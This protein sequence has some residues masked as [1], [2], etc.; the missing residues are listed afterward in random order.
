MSRPPVEPDEYFPEYGDVSYDVLHYDLRLVYRVDGN[1][2]EGHAELHAVARTDVDELHLDLRGLSVSK[3]RV[4]VAEVAKFTVRRG[5]LVV[6]TRQV[7]EEGQE[8]RLTIRYDGKPR[9]ISDGGG[10][11]GWEE[12]TDGVLVAGQTNGAASWFPCNDRP[13]NK[14]SYR[15]DVTTASPYY[16]VANG[17]LTSRRQGAGRTTWVYE[18]AE[19]M[20]TYLAT[21]QIGRYL[22]REVPGSPVPM[23]AMLPEGRLEDFHAGFGR[24]PEMMDFFVRSFGPYPF[25]SYAVVITE[26]P[27]EIPLEAQSLSIFGSNFLTDDWDS[28]RLVAHELSHQWFGNSVTA[29]SWRDIWLHEGFACYAEWLWSEESGGPSAHERAVEHWKKLDQ[30]PQD[31]LLG[32]PG[33]DDMFDDRVYKRGALLLHTLR[34]EVGDDTFFELLQEWTRRHAH[35]SVTTALFIELA[36]D[37]T[38]RPLG[39][40][41]TAWLEETEL[42]ALPS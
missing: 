31:L 7:I 14:A 30:L 6:R 18:Q 38:E 9:A 35:G 41:F 4:D 1:R 2:L 19:P 25:G 15:I 26:D 12:L 20:A 21:V 8:F 32:D 16:V 17:E 29:T 24:Q 37:V 39:D 42:P 27:L 13:S 28:V 11:M 36:E 10:D 34:A 33:P 22:A 3:V 23:T 40:L 5:K